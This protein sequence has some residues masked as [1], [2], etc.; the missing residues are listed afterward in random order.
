MIDGVRVAPFIASRAGAVGHLTKD[1]IRD[2]HD[3]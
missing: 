2:R 1:C 3:S